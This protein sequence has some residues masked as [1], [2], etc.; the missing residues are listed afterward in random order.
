MISI[1]EFSARQWSKPLREANASKVKS[2][3]ERELWNERVAEVDEALWEINYAA[4]VE[5]ISQENL[6]SLYQVV[7]QQ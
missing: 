2:E 5:D 7:N 1:S 4:F 6:I 3:L